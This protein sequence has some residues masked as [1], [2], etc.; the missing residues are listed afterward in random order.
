MALIVSGRYLPLHRKGMFAHF[1]KKTDTLECPFETYA[2]SHY[3]MPYLS[4]VALER[5]FLLNDRV[6]VFAATKGADT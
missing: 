4:R 1:D 3:L 5:A 2:E 6:V